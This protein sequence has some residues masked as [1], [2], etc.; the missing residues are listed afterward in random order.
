MTAAQ[1]DL[2]RPLLDL[3][4]EEVAVLFGEGESVV[5]TPYLDAV[6]STARPAVLHTAYRSL[7]ARGLVRAGHGDLL[8]AAVDR[9]V[10]RGAGRLDLDLELA[11]DLADIVDIR[12]GAPVLLCLQRTLAND[13]VLRYAH[14]VGDFVLF[15]DVLPAGLHRFAWLARS[16][17]A[18]CL[19]AFLVP[20][21]AA[22]GP[23]AAPATLTMAAEDA[24][25]LDLLGQAVVSVDATVRHV[26]D[27]G[28]G[29]LLGLFLGPAGTWATRNSFG[30]HG[31]IVIEPVPAAS[32]GAMVLQ[33]VTDA[34]RVVRDAGM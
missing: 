11:D 5:A 25:M 10:E 20:D 7:L 34:E 17:F 13:P 24:P 29:V 6:P 18:A 28:P 23:V 15:E 14:I 12:D 21:D 4:D 2:P 22:D 9:A 33:L 16:A 32:V 26:A 3:T 30:A 31:E 27:D 8:E 19:Q 1:G